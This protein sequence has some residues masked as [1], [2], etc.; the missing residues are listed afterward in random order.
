MACASSFRRRSS[1]RRPRENIE[2][3]NV[4][5]DR[6]WTPTMTFSI[7]VIRGHSA[8]FWNVRNT[9]TRLISWACIDS[10]SSPSN[11]TVPVVGS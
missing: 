3:R 4:C 7:T 1:L 9:P 10:R 5:E 8:R 11:R 2:V 6:V